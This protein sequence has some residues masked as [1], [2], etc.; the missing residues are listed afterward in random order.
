KK[1]AKLVR[2]LNVSGHNPATSG[3]YSLRST[4]SPEYALVSESGIDKGL[5]TEDNLILVDIKSAKQHEIFQGL[6]KKSSDETA[7]HLAVYK[8][9]DANCVRHS[10]MLEGI[11]FAEMFPGESFLKIA[12]LE[13]LKGLKGIKTH[14]T[15]VQI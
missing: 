6:G 4:T 9:T 13:L 12:G 1:L 8:A 7:L 3:N 15:K 2:S 10:H 5:F 14:E 11:L